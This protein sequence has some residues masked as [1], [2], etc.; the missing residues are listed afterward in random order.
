[1]QML[2][3]RETK[4]RWQSIHPEKTRRT[5]S[6]NDGKAS[7]QEDQSDLG[8]KASARLEANAHSAAKHL[9]ERDQNDINDKE[10]IGEESIGETNGG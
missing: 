4:P 10:S 8:G 9:P 1:M 3:T 5:T 6:N 2:P 7:T